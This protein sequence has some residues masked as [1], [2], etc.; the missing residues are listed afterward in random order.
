M[1][2]TG[3]CT[4][5]ET[6]AVEEILQRIASNL[7]LLMDHDFQLDSIDAESWDQRPVGPGSVHISFKL[8]F[9]GDRGSAEG[10]LLVPLEEGMTLA[11]YLM[12]AS[13][14]EV[15]VTRELDEPDRSAK[16]AMLE[17][18]NFIASATGSAFRDLE[19]GEIEVYSEGC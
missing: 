12:M 13:D 4:E 10:C 17:L 14:E 1:P 8:S 2:S 11:G 3:T 9:E 15:A 6:R 5:V 16:D 18:A 7:A 19:L